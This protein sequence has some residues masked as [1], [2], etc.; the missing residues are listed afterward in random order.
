M[1]E[2]TAT[3]GAAGE[4]SEWMLEPFLHFTPGGVYNLVTDRSA[5]VHSETATHLRALRSAYWL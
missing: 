4:D 2:T 1:S 3:P 5:G